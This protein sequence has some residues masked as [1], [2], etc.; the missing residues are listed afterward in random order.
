M[1]SGKENQERPKRRRAM[2]NSGYF[3]SRKYSIFGIFFT[4]TLLN[5]NNFNFQEKKTF[6]HFVF[7][8]IF[9]H[10][11]PFVQNS[12]QAKHET[13]P[14]FGIIWKTEKKEANETVV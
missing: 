1:Q 8:F 11:K 6:L 12:N 10:F 2:R 13:I 9:F 14:D 3:F 4:N 5:L 7:V